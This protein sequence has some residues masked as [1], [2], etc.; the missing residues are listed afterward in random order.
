MVLLRR[1]RQPSLGFNRVDGNTL[2]AQVHVA[3][4]TL[5]IGDSG[6]C[7]LRDVFHQ[8]RKLSRFEECNYSV[9]LIS[10]LAHV[11][12]VGIVCHRMPYGEEN[13]HLGSTR[14]ALGGP[15]ALEKNKRTGK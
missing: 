8:L 2:T 15:P 6:L 12:S 1:L 9:E 14:R 10:S 4:L 11:C 7:K 13:Q 3:K 5:G